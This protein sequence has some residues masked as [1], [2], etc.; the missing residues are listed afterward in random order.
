[1]KFMIKESYIKNIDKNLYINYDKDL[2]YFCKG[3][4]K[5]IV[6]SKFDTL[7]RFKIPWD[8]KGGYCVLTPKLP[9]RNSFSSGN[10]N[11]SFME[12]RIKDTPK[13]RVKL[14]FNEGLE[15]GIN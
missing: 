2:G 3:E 1:M 7:D 11:K 9:I 4:Y 12:N 5:N 8:N 6:F 10:L 14:Y 15:N 13:I